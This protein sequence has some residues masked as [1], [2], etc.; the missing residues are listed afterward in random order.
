MVWGQERES[1]RRHRISSEIYLLVE[2]SWFGSSSTEVGEGQGD[3]G[4]GRINT[5]HLKGPQQPCSQ[6][7]ATVSVQGGSEEGLL[8]SDQGCKLADHGTRNPEGTEGLTE[9][10]GARA[11]LGVGMWRSSTKHCEDKGTETRGA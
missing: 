4:H 8:G 10:E 1:S 2:K 11:Q 3:V 9:R 6:M 5:L 7:A